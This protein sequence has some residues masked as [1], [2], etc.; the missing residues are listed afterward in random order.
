LEDGPAIDTA[1]EEQRDFPNLLFREH[2][3]SFFCFGRIQ[4]ESPKVKPFQLLLDVAFQGRLL[5]PFDQ[6]L[7]G[8]QGV[9]A[10]LH[11]FPL[12]K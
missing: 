12:R 10:C 5:Q 1:H 4:E 2:W 7:D 8:L 11:Y 6:R 9:G 3:G